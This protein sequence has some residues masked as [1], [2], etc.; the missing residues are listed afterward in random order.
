[1]ALATLEYQDIRSAVLRL[2]QRQ[3]LQLIK[4]AILTLSTEEP[5]TVTTVEFEQTVAELQKAFAHAT[6]TSEQ[7]VDDARY[8]YLAEKYGA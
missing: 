7:T 2:P 4:E 1:M 8:A 6:S 5:P 3:R